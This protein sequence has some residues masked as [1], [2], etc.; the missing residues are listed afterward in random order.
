MIQAVSGVHLFDT[1]IFL[2]YIYSIKSLRTE[3]CEV[4][5][6]TMAVEYHG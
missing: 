6:W 1:A 5:L 3:E 4:P 2:C